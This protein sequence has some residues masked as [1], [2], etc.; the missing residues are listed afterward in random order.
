MGLVVFCAG[1][2]ASEESPG[3]L[4]SFSP[5]GPGFLLGGSYLGG[6]GLTFTLILFGVNVDSGGEDGRIRRL[7]CGVGVGGRGGLHQLGLAVRGGRFI[8]FMGY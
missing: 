6:G 3:S 8:C 7:G 2:S 5:K 1:G 4:V